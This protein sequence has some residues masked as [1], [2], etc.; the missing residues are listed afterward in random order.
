MRKYHPKGKK[1]PAL[2]QNILKYRAFE[3]VIILFHIEELKSFSLN[4][5]RATDKI[6]Y[7]NDET[8]HRLPPETKKLYEKMWALLVSDGVLTQ[9]E[10]DDLQGIIDYRNQI[11]HSI[12]NLTFDISNEAISEDY[13]QFQ[14]VKYDYEA[15]N[16]LEVYRDK[17]HSELRSKYILP[18]GFNSLL[19]ESA[20]YTYKQELKRLDK[21]IRRLLAIRNDEIKAINSDLKA[22][23]PNLI[24]EIQPYHPDNFLQNGQLSK[25]GVNC[26]YKL[27]DN[28]LSNLAVSY[29]MRI[30]FIS[31]TKRR[32]SWEIENA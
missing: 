4:A 26:C 16:R 11:A 2:E 5:I 30:S 22:I 17:I 14:G 3:M 24:D 7:P 29:L 6:R 9:E 32:E 15:L 27:F 28:G 21:K 10:S 25:R 20:K 8:R 19:F 23:D 18:A 31:V 13:V 12:Q 1:L